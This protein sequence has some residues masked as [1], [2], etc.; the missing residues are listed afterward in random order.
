MSAKP[1]YLYDTTLRDGTQGEGFQLSVLDKLRIF[2][3]SVSCNF[4]GRAIGTDRRAGKWELFAMI[5]PE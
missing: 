4:A 1:A 2:I 5:V 3:I